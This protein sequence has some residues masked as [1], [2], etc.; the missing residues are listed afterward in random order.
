MYE[1]LISNDDFELVQSIR[2]QRANTPNRNYR[3]TMFSGLTK[4]G[5]CGFGVSRRTT[6]YNKV[7]KCNNKERN[8][9]CDLRTIHEDELFAL[10]QKHINSNHT[11]IFER[12]ENLK[13]INIYDD[14]VE[15]V[16]DG[17]I[18]IAKRGV[19]NGT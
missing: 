13:R 9:T 18:K 15:F 17:K 7:W 2:N 14:K 3:K 1:P 8:K 10:Y 4:C 19:K 12:D 5:C 6:K 11:D 16:L